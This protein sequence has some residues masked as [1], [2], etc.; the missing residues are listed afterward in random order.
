MARNIRK[1]Y[2]NYAGTDRIKKKRAMR[3]KA[4][5]IMIRAGKARKGDG[6]DVDHKNGDVTDNR[7][8][9]LKMVSRSKNRS[10]PR[11]KTAGKKNKTD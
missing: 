5:R 11:T 3:N 6:M 7:L 10:Y 4:R 8:S 2:E 9:N 1:E